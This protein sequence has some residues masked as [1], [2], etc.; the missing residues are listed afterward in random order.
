MGRAFH[1]YTHWTLHL[2]PEGRWNFRAVPPKPAIA[3][4]SPHSPGFPPPRSRSAL[5]GS[6]AFQVPITNR[7]RQSP[8]PSPSRPF[9]PG[10]LR[11]LRIRKGSDEKPTQ[12]AVCATASPIQPHHGIIEVSA[13]DSLLSVGPQSPSAALSPGHPNAKDPLGRIQGGLFHAARVE[14]HRW[15]RETPQRA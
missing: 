5:A 12:H 3:K 14:R 6:H 11:R 7:S 2:A 1:I 10:A 8:G 15:H 9:L 13:D 4:S